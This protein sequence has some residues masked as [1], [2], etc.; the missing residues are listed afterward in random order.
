MTL[1]P[2]DAIHQTTATVSPEQT[3]IPE[4]FT[5]SIKALCWIHAIWRGSRTARAAR[6]IPSFVS[7]LGGVA[8]NLGYG[9]RRGVKIAAQAVVIALRVVECVENYAALQ[10]YFKALVAELKGHAIVP[11][12]PSWKQSLKPGFI[13]P[14]SFQALKDA[15]GLKWYRTKRVAYLCAM[16][17]YHIFDLSMCV[18]DATQALSID[19]DYVNDNINE[20]FL[21]GYDLWN[22][23][24]SDLP[25]LAQKL[26][27]NSMVIDALIQNISRTPVKTSQL[28]KVC[29]A[30]AAVREKTCNAAGIVKNVVVYGAEKAVN[31]AR[32]AVSAIADKDYID[33]EI[34]Y[35]DD[36]K[37]SPPVWET[38]G[39]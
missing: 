7:Y 30:A 2:I 33:P 34:R 15:A 28:L 23:L 12:K 14:S 6:D 38:G 16:I 29:T 27:E 26:N 8:L 31:G 18:F 1:E 22:K 4:F 35:I 32:K 21:N 9:D 10:I 5:K 13:P 39:K 24:T 3:R 36:E 19:N 17:A 25:F 11:L 20:I 37:I